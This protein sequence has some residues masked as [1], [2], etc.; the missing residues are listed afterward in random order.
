MSARRWPVPR[1]LKAGLLVGVLA[2]ATFAVAELSDN[3]TIAPTAVLLG[4][5][6]GPFA[7]AV[8]VTDR[9]RV[10]R[11]VP[12][13]VLFVT[14]LV[15]GGVAIVF[16]GFFEADLF[17]SSTDFGYLWVGFI[18]ETAKVIAP[19]AICTAVMKYRSVEQALAFAIV[20]AGGFATFESMTFALFALDDDNARAARRVLLERTFV[21]PFGHLPWTAIAVVVAARVWQSA[22][23][24]VITPRALWGLGAAIVLHTFWNVALV[25]GRWWNV[26]IPVIAATT[27][28]LFR[29]V[30]SGVFYA[31]PY[32]IP[33]D[34]YALRQR[35]NGRSTAELAVD[36]LGG[37]NAVALVPPPRRD[38]RDRPVHGGEREGP[39]EPAGL[40]P[41]EPVHDE[42][43]HEAVGDVERERHRAGVPEDLDGHGVDEPVSEP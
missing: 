33:T 9:T 21:T 16:T 13:D 36:P 20:T 29:R 42:I 26:A 35:A 18:E 14:F 23:R 43:E 31:G 41:A 37:A 25:K 8:W 5:L 38:D 28:L 30:I 22:R 27:L 19:L 39:G 4:A 12:P 32:A 11:S 17:Y 3:W 40:D 34:H 6:A 7:F 24:I 2:G 10:G 15:G 1:W